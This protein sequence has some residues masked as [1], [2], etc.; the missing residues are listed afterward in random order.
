MQP[1]QHPNRKTFLTLSIELS[2]AAWKLAATDGRHPNP[3]LGKLQTEERWERLQELLAWTEAQRSKWG[4]PPG[5]QVV[6]IYEAGQDGFWI[7]R[8]LQ[9]AG[10]EVFVVDPA[11]VPVSRHARRAK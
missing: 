2:G 11:S 1:A 3:T 7:A 4:L 5:C 6:V 9:A 8:A 10:I